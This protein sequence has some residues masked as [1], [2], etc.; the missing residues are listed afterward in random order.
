MASLEVGP[1]FMDVTLFSPLHGDGSPMHNAASQDGAALRRADHN[2]RTRDYPDV[3]SSDQAQFL[4]L[5]CETSGRLSMH[6][7][8]LLQQLVKFKASNHV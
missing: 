7:L 4:S 3:E 5:G 8:Q 2:N 1:L 6:S